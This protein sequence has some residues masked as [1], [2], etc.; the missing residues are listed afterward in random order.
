MAPPPM[1]HI[2]G[3]SKAKKQENSENRKPRMQTDRHGFNTKQKTKQLSCVLQKRFHRGSV[4]EFRIEF[5]DFIRVHP[6]VS[7]VSI[8]FFSAP[9]WLMA[10]RLHEFSL[11]ML[12][13]HFHCA[14]LT[15]WKPSE[16]LQRPRMMSLRAYR[17]VKT[18]N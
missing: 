18:H 14:I 11:T 9:I 2:L 3:E 17:V 15:Y 10:H 1:A 5:V 7:M 12:R 13:V 6:C 4:F 8:L 16:E